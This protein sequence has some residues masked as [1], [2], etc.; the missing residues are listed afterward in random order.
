MKF[1]SWNVNG[2]RACLNKG[3]AESM[4]ALDADVICVQETK[5]QPGQ[6]TWQMNG[7]EAYWHYAQKKGYSGTAVFTRVPP[8]SVST[9]IGF[10]EFDAEGRSVTLEF[11]DYYLV[12]IYAPNSQA[13]LARIEFRLAW[14]ASL[15]TYLKQLELSKPVIL[16]G[17]FNVAHQDIDLKNPQANYGNTGFSDAERGAFGQLLE[18]GF[19]DTFRLLHPQEV[20]VYTW[21]SYQFSARKTNAGWRIDYF[22]VS[23]ALENRVKAAAVHMEIPGS[24][25]CP[26]ELIVE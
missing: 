9:G 19:A 15:L 24:D 10:P 5:L 11:E 3:F 16:C 1:V 25:H 4:A 22:L 6:L 2:L 21:W 14:E 7:Y 17:D 13:A 12:N 18:S 26:V 23:R 20:G 8:L